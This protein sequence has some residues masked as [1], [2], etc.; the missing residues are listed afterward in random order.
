[1][2]MND[3]F[4]VHRNTLNEMYKSEKNKIFF[5]FSLFFFLKQMNWLCQPCLVLLCPSV[6][7]SGLFKLEASML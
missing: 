3:N 4:K 5:S 1:M 7:S 2:K 6:V